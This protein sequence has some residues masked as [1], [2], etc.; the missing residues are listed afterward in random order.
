MINRE[1]VEISQPGNRIRSA[2][3][4]I[5]NVAY[6]SRTDTLQLLEI[7]RSLEN[8][9]QKIR[10]SLFQESLPDN[11]QALYVLLKDIETLGGW[12]YIYRMR[13]RELIDK[14]DSEEI[15]N[16]TADPQNYPPP[17]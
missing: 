1:D 7:L 4:D 3:E 16:L 17:S 11:R 13:L 14:L 12:P 5:W 6:E 15:T 9:H 2:L 8:L 10:D